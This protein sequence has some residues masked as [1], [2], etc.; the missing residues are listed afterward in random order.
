MSEPTGGG[1][2]YGLLTALIAVAAPVTAAVH[3]IF[4]QTTELEI[5]R[6]SKAKELELATR[7]QDFEMRMDFLDRAID[8]RRSPED[9]QQVLRFLRAVSADAALKE[10]AEAELSSVQQDVDTFRE[11]RD[12]LAQALERDSE[13]EA[14]LGATAVRSESAEGPTAAKAEAERGVLR[15][16]ARVQ[17]LQR[18]RALDQSTQ[19]GEPPAVDD[20]SRSMAAPRDRASTDMAP[21]T[22]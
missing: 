6:V 18:L 15:A 13:I 22:K 11:A 20:S 7:A 1:I 19:L 16:R 12:Q 5:A 4:S 2:R 17:T 14:K 9:R 3:G 8:A 21:K 10:W